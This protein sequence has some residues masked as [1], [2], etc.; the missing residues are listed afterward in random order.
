MAQPD[1]RRLL[2]L[3]ACLRFMV[4]AGQSAATLL[5]GMNFPSTS[6]PQHASPNQHNNV[7][8]KSVCSKSPLLIPS[9][10]SLSTP[11]KVDAKST[12]LDCSPT[13]AVE[14]IQVG[15]DSETESGSRLPPRRPLC[16]G[17]LTHKSNA[18]HSTPTALRPKGVIGKRVLDRHGR[19]QVKTKG[20]E[21]LDHVEEMETSKAM[22]LYAYD[23]SLSE[24]YVI[25]ICRSDISVFCW[26][27][28]RLPLTATAY[29][30]FTNCF[31]FLS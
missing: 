31:F 30:F 4:S 7:Q 25:Y 11:P 16:F 13:A 21:T 3:E 22:L 10:C 12:G 23:S 2:K 14:V 17:P 9:Q 24:R 18:G 19:G 28:F 15:S 5:E 27:C 26:F 29:P 20:K 8:S 6:V 1:D